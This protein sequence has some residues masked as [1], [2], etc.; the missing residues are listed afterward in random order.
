MRKFKIT[1]QFNGEP[2][3]LIGNEIVY[4]NDEYSARHAFLY[5]HPVTYSVLNCQELPVD[6]DEK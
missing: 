4:A 6:Q 1:W 5:A 2:D 3:N